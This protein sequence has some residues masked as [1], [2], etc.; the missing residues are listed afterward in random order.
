MSGQRGRPRSS[1][2][3]QAILEATRDLLT[4]G[5]YERLTIEAIAAR[6]GVGKQTVYRWW[7]SKAAIVAEAV[8]AGVIGGPSTVLD[9]TG[10]IAADLGSW[11][12]QMTSGLGDPQAGALTRALTVASAERETDA[13]RLYEKSV[14]PL[15]DNLLRRL[16]GAASAGQIRPDADLEAV[17]DA[18]M[19][20]AL[21]RVL[22]RSA[23]PPA[24]Y[25]DGLLAVL[26]RGIAAPGDP[27]APA[28]P[29]AS[30]DPVASSD[31]AASAS[32]PVLSRPQVGNLET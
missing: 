22:A 15:R 12:Q 30:G 13:E 9:D 26:L 5:G 31:R 24:A 2:A 21:Y 28:D 10:D 17:A 29:V 23:P 32:E 1:E 27:V 7:P 20:V 14:A 8:L 18:I 3:H 4:I 19:G 16:S 25:G 6:A 11:I